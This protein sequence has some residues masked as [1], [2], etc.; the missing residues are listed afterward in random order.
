MAHNLKNVRASGR[1]SHLLG[2]IYAT[3]VKDI[4]PPGLR[5]H[6]FLM[7]VTGVW[8]TAIDS[9]SYKWQTVAFFFFIGVAFPCSQFA[10]IFFTTTI[11]EAMDFSFTSLSVWTSAFKTAVI[12]W[13]RDN[14]RELFGIHGQLSY[15][16]GR[17]ADT[18][19][20]VARL[21]TLVHVILTLF[22]LLVVGAAV[23]QTIFSR[24]EDAIIPSTSRLPYHFAARRDVYWSVLMAQVICA[25][26]VIIWTAIDDSFFI[27][28]INI[29]L[30]HLGEL[31]MRFEGL[32]SDIGQGERN[33]D[34][35]FDGDLVECCRRY[36]NC[37]R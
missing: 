7:R 22:Y 36:E 5:S 16:S 9:P 3:Q 28:L 37:L 23:A 32:G 1:L 8:P 33:R 13:R 12:Y 14:I 2:R 27:A 4:V 34:A 11:E 29:A 24:P 15:G 6:V 18:N 10:N 21:N 35:R 17:I 25:S 30:G 19:R 26:G 31:K 20:R